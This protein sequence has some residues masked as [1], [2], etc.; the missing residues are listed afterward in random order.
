M[1]LGFE[2][3]RTERELVEMTAKAEALYLNSPNKENPEALQA[4]LDGLWTSQ[5]GSLDP[6]VDADRVKF[7]QARAGWDTI[8]SGINEQVRNDAA[9]ALQDSI[10]DDV[11]MLARTEYGDNGRID[12]DRMNDRL[13]NELKI[14]GPRANDIMLATARELAETNADPELLDAV[15]DKW[16][17]GAAS[18]RSIPRNV[19]AMAASRRAAENQRDYNI[20][21]EE[22]ASAAALK[23]RQQQNSAQVMFDIINGRSRKIAVGNL[24]NA[25]ELTPEE[26]RALVAF[27]G[28]PAI[29]GADGNGSADWSLVTQI[30]VGL[31]LGQLSQ[32]DVIEAAN[33]AGFVGREGASAIKSLLETAR[34][35]LDDRL[36]TPE[37][38]MYQKELEA[39][40][41]PLQ[42]PFDALNFD[43]DKDRIDRTNQ[44]TLLRLYQENLLADMKP[45]PAMLKAI[46][47]GEIPTVALPKMTGP[48]IDA[49][50]E[51][52]TID[53]TQAIDLYNQ[54]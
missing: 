18:F 32:A 48:Q 23:A 42:S 26:G 28:S 38:I 30:E 9:K 39:R 27:E 3:V 22:A 50:L 16:A 41:N 11:T 1:V 2:R 35:T 40:S 52:G 21:R 20:R 49:L 7:R 37:A 15:P 14:S 19:D 13:V 29:A 34:M 45:L 36:K 53:E 33:G 24:V 46:K 17:N 12:W 5:F 10:E 47:E 54:L 4:E 6:E 43:G 51:A 25:G 44:V 31:R 8:V